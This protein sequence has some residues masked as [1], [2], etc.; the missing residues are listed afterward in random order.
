A[1]G[2]LA[3]LIPVVEQSFP[4]PEG[5]SLKLFQDAHLAPN[6]SPLKDFV[7]GDI[8]KTL[9]VLMGSIGLVLLIACANVAN[10][11]LV[12]VEGRSQELAVR[13]ALGAGRGRIAAELMLESVVLGLA[14]GALGLGVAYAALRGLEV[15]APAGLPR[16]HE[17]GV[18]W[19]VAIFAFSA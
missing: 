7:V 19:N 3:R 17:I 1:S 4:T 11:L 5:F 2:D 16:V 9:W 18:D 6:L 15:I 12:R 13:S 14:A 10:L 8:G